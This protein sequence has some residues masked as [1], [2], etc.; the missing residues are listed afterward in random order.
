MTAGSNTVKAKAA[1][2][3]E[4]SDWMAY[5]ITSVILCWSKQVTRTI[6][7]KDTEKKLI[8]WWQK[9][10]SHCKVVCALERKEFEATLQSIRV[11]PLTTNYSYP[12]MHTTCS[13]PFQD[14]Q[15]LIL[16]Y[17]QTWSPG[18]ISLHSPSAWAEEKKTL[19]RKKR[20][21]FQF[22]LSTPKSCVHRWLHA[23]M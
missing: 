20:K 3:L 17:K 19:H 13:F 6:R 10:M 9:A 12:S 21:K 23:R 7:F 14:S 8:S 15:N 4:A 16:L 5:N 2:P 1:K 18:S 22:P 11:Y